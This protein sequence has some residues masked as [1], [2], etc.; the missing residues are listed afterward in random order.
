MNKLNELKAAMK[1][2]V[3]LQE[4][5]SDQGADNSEQGVIFQQILVDC[6]AMRSPKIPLDAEGW[7]LYEHTEDVAQALSE[8]TRK[9]IDIIENCVFGELVDIQAYIKLYCWRATW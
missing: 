8:S 7:D 6:L 1:E 3:K 4:K 5:F 9:C 2:F